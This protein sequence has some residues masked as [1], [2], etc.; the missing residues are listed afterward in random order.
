MKV[1]DYY[2]EKMVDN[3]Y[4]IDGRKLLCFSAGSCMAALIWGIVY[5]EKSASEIPIASFILFVICFIS[6]IFCLLVGLLTIDNELQAKVRNKLKEYKSLRKKTLEQHPYKYSIFTGYTHP[7]EEILC[8]AFYVNN[9]GQ[10]A[11]VSPY[12]LVDD[13]TLENWKNYLFIID[14]TDGHKMV[15]KEL[16]AFLVK[17][18][19][20]N[21]SRS[22]SRKGAAK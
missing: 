6:F 10:T 9:K 16:N 19:S 4:P 20:K 17:D 21:R 22:A 5:N 7:I 13:I 3:A 2:D 14:N 1:L 11:V 12:K 15:A 18:K 8:D